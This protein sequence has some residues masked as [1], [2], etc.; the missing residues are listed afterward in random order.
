ER[1]TRMMAEFLT[2]ERIYLRPMRREDARTFTRWMN[3]VE[4]C[5]TLNWH[6]PLT[7]EAEEAWLEKKL[8][9]ERDVMLAICLHEGQR[10]IG[11]TDLRLGQ[12][13]DRAAMFGI[14]IGAKEEW[15]KGYGT[16]ATR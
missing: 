16:E 10:L 12:E 1:A 6:R 4:V 3:D 8:K 13:K 15:N 9:E 14:M 5:S 11:A 2:S 7:L